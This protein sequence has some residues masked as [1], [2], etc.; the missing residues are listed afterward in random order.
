MAALNIGVIMARVRVAELEALNR[1]AD[2]IATD[3]R[4]R[5]PIRKSFREP[6]GYR[7]KFRSLTAME[8]RIATQRANQFYTQVRP[9]EFA[10]RRAVAHIRNYAR[11]E[12]PRQGSN[13]ALSR[14]RG[15]RQL[16]F[17]RQGRFVST[18]G[19][20]PR[21]GGGF[22]PGARLS[23]LLTARGRSE[24]RSGAAI[25]RTA[26]GRIQIGG[27]LKASIESEGAVQS[28]KGAT[29]RVTAAI[30]YAKFVEFPTVRTAAQPF[31]RP[32]LHNARARLV[33]EIAR[34]VRQALRGQ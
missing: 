12:I 24:V 6:K 33:E 1:V 7:R 30:G 2:Q 4:S 26:E 8:Q 5:A 9:D 28:A 3:A 23:G 22:E 21:R 34:E 10:R 20:F 18:S 27:A 31:L 13:N 29:A 32:A 11:A 17:I 14:S 15:N 25:H 16:G 19:A